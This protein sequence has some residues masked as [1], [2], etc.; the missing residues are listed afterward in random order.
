MAPFT[1]FA[2]SICTCVMYSLWCWVADG[3]SIMY[4]HHT[5]ASQNF[6]KFSVFFVSLRAPHFFYRL[7][8][9]SHLS[10]TGNFHINHVVKENNAMKSEMT[11][12]RKMMMKLLLLLLLEDEDGKQRRKKLRLKMNIYIYCCSSH[13]AG[14]VH[15]RVNTTKWML[16][17]WSCTLIC[18]LMW[19]LW[20][21]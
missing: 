6:P 11:D 3:L 9:I 18:I 4:H 5:I 19:R 14:N 17:W 13:C 7:K 21:L 20:W 8:M 1:A 2:I 12:K 16:C 10:V 15:I